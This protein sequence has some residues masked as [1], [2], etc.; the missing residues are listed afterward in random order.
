M[1]VLSDFI[2]E[3]DGRVQTGGPLIYILILGLFM[4]IAAAMGPNDGARRLAGYSGPTVELNIRGWIETVFGVSL[5][6]TGPL[7]R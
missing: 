3:T 5:P 6:Q 7:N 1:R 2:R 4:S